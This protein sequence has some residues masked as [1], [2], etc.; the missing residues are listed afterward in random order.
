MIEFG[1]IWLDKDTLIEIGRFETL[2]YSKSIS[3]KAT[4]IH[5]ITNE[6][7]KYSPKFADIASE[8]YYILHGT[9]WMGHNINGFDS[10]VIRKHFEKIDVP[11]PTPF[12]TIDTLPL[13]RSTFG[14]RAGNL[15]MA[16][17]SEYFNLGKE[18]HRAT[19]DCEVTL[20]V[21]KRSSLFMHVDSSP[22]FDKK[23]FERR[24]RYSTAISTPGTS[25][26]SS[27]STSRATKNNNNNASSSSLASSTVSDKQFQEQ[28]SNLHRFLQE[29]K[30]DLNRALAKLSSKSKEERDPRERLIFVIGNEAM[31]LDSHVS[32][33]GYAYYKERVD[34]LTSG[35]AEKEV[36]DTKE[37]EKEKEKMKEQEQK[38]EDHLQRIYIPLM[39]IPREEFALRGECVH[40]F[41]KVGLSESDLIFLDDVHLDNLFPP[42]SSST[43]PSSSSPSSPS[44]SSSLPGIIL[45]DHNKL[46]AAKSHLGMYVEEIIDHHHDEGAYKEHVFST[47]RIISPVGS[48][49]T[50]V[51]KSFFDFAD[52][53]SG[54]EKI[55]DEKRDAALGQLLLETILLDTVNLDYKMKKVTKDDEQVAW[56]LFNTF[57]TSVEELAPKHSLLREA[58]KRKEGGTEKDDDQGEKVDGVEN[59]NKERSEISKMYSEEEKKLL[60]QL[61][62]SIQVRDTSTILYLTIVYIYIYIYI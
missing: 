29:A 26:S 40:L 57:K 61:F 3:K 39:N 12:D 10:A 47:H 27:P 62:E 50:L 36:E 35:Q 1:A 23:K 7:V 5:G 13:L 55:L 37:K 48:A 11:P 41:S 34:Q 30:E 16:T 2:L 32:S 9:I 58:E 19:D 20:D 49:T 60:S 25:S 51:A 53:Y 31:D 42:V 38:M 8:I 46:D 43:S 44:S 17:L 52:N 18:A 24:R 4:A 14:Y 28:N 45:V 21:M 6:D 54:K 56:N 15:K 33:I 59:T 22:V